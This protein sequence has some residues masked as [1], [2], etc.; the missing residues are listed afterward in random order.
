MIMILEIVTMVMTI[1]GDEGDVS[2]G[3]L[4]MMMV[5]IMMIMMMVV[6]NDGVGRMMVIMT[7]VVIG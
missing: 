7:M 1:Y 5:V 4:V 6:I 3:D 2:N